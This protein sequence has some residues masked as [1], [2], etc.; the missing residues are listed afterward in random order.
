ME[1]YEKAQKSYQRALD[2]RRKLR[3]ENH[4]DT[5]FIGHST[6][7]IHLIGKYEDALKKRTCKAYGSGR[8][9]WVTITF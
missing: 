3:I 5:A 2:L 8:Y 1:R 4:E 7:Q 9:I 6:G